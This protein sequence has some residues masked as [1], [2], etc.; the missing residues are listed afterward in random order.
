[1][2][3]IK[4]QFILQESKTNTISTITKKTIDNMAFSGDLMKTVRSVIILPL[5]SPLLVC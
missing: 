1:M 5:T 2:I 4:I 3:L